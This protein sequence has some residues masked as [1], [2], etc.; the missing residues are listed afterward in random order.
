LS[1]L[2]GAGLLRDTPLWWADLPPSPP[3]EAVALPARADVA[4]IGGGYTGLSAARSLARG[5]ASV[6]VLEKHTLGFGASSR[7][8]GQVLT[9]LKP[10]AKALLARFGRERARALFQV[11]LQAI[12][13]V[14]QLVA[15]ERIECGFVR[16]GHLDAACKPSHLQRLERERDVL[17]REFGHPVRILPRAEQGAELGSAYYHGLLVDERSAALQ[18][19]RYLRGLAQ[20]AARAGAGLHEHTPAERLERVP[21]GF[22]V[23][24]PRGALAA[25]DVLVATNGYTD[26]ALP[27][28]RRRV[29]PV[30]SFIVATRPITPAQASAVLPRR[31]VAF[32][33]RRFLHYFRVSA[34]ERLVFGGRAQFTPASPRST[35]R[36]AEILQR[37]LAQ[38]FPELAGV[39]IE[40]AWSGNVCF[41]PDLLPR[42]GRL[43]GVHYALGYAGHGVAMA[44]WLGD[45]IADALL[46]RADRNPFGALPFRAIPLYRGEP[47]F[48]PLAGLAYKVL[49]WLD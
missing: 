15:S 34:D 48:L 11:S 33:S 7:N 2:A 16:C 36:S 47:W 31:R 17:E 23:L 20:A 28:L 13:F 26:S 35:R 32:D 29:V 27:A 14:E 43:D 39:G 12:D 24:T 18:P 37:E 22:R 40:Y 44:S 21:G 6:V 8:G 42:A 19:A 3:P 45:A 10:G 49:D 5:G 1:A 4:V 46:G 38:V 41:T 9:G 25:R 30:G